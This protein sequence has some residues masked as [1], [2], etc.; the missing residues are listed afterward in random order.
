MQSWL[1]LKER[2]K[3]EIKSSPTPI[4]ITSPATSA[5]KSI[6]SPKST[7]PPQMSSCMVPL[8]LLIGYF[9]T[10]FRP[11]KTSQFS[12]TSSQPNFLSRVN[13]SLYHSELDSLHHCLHQLSWAIPS[14]I[15]DK[16]CLKTKYSQ[17]GSKKTESS[18]L[19]VSSLN[20]TTIETMSQASGT[21]QCKI[22]FKHEALNQQSRESFPISLLVLPTN[23]TTQ[24]LNTTTTENHLANDH[25]R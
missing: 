24:L 11:S 5:P 25:S 19:T 7:K 16:T 8:S 15:P 10:Y 18:T 3:K 6:D 13:T 2:T 21:Q 4:K 12:I 14:L 9:D 17:P 22:F 1:K 23:H 20:L